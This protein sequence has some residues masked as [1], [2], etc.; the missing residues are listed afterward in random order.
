MNI[1]QRIKKLQ[2]QTTATDSEFC[3]CEKQRTVRL[4]GEPPFPETCK[5]C[6]KPLLIIHVTSPEMRGEI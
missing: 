6:G 5:R 2:N 4:P 3:T 1:L